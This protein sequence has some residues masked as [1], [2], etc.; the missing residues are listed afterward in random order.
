VKLIDATLLTR[1]RQ[2]RARS[3]VGMSGRPDPRA[4][5]SPALTQKQGTVAFSFKAWCTDRGYER[6]EIAEATSTVKALMRICGKDARHAVADGAGNRVSL[7]GNSV[8]AGQSDRRQAGTSQRGAR[9]WWTNRSR[10][11]LR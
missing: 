3:G 1:R 7:F 9:R 2:A 10:Y 4:G 5:R 8:K 11:R 6:E